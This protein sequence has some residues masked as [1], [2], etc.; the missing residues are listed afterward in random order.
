MRQRGHL[1]GGAIHGNIF[2]TGFVSRL[3][4]F[5]TWLNFK[6]NDTVTGRLS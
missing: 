2:Y 5:E 4:G 6:K 3:S 1:T